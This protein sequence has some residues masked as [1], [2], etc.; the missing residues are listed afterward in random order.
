MITPPFGKWFGRPF[1][2]AHGP[3]CIEGLTIPSLS[4]EGEW[5]GF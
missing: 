4:K 2:R 5:E 3:E 1:D